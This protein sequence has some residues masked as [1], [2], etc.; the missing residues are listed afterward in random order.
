[1]IRIVEEFSR[2]FE[3]VAGKF[4]FKKELIPA[5]VL[6]DVY[7]S[8]SREPYQKVIYSKDEKKLELYL[9]T[10][11]FKQFPNRIEILTSN[12]NLDEIMSL[13]HFENIGG[14]WMYYPPV[15]ME[16]VFN[17]GENPFVIE[18]MQLTTE[19]V[20]QIFNSLGE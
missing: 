6:S 9:D 17:D 12:N 16:K 19:I 10:I 3:A 20:E 7:N 8:F 11:A 2:C 1:M 15:D 4:N 18:P 5:Y 13:N 14:V